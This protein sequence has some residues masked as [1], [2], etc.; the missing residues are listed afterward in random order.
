MRWVDGITLLV[1]GVPSLIGAEWEAGNE[2]LRLKTLFREEWEAR[3][4]SDPLT[5][6]LVGEH[7]W[8]SELPDLRLTEREASQARD[9]QFLDRLRDIDRERLSRGERVSCDLFEFELTRRMKRRGFGEHRLPFTSDSGFY[10]TLLRGFEKMRLRHERDAEIYLSRLSKVPVYLEQNVDLMRQGMA[11]GFTMPR[12]IMPGIERVI[13]GLS[14]KS[15]TEHPLFQ[16]FMLGLERLPSSRRSEWERRLRTLMTSR[17]LPAFRDLDSFVRETYS[18]NA[19]TSLG[20]RDLPGGEEY[21]RFLVADFTT[22]DLDPLEIHRMG[23]REVSRIRKE[24]ET[25]LNQLEFQG[26]F[27]DFLN[28]LRTDPQFYAQS[29]DQLLKEA[30]WIAKRVDGILPAY[31]ETLPRMPYGVAPVPRHL[32]P[33]YTTGRY[34]PGV[35]GGERGGYYWVNTFALEKR[36]LYA[37]PA[38]TLHEAMPG[39][40]LQIAL[41]QELTD[42]PDFRRHFYPNAFG[43]GWALYAEKLG[44]E[45]GVYQTIYEEFGCLTYEIW[46]AGRLVVDTGIHMMGWSRARAVELFVENSALSLHN[47]ETEVDRYIS[48][49]GQALSYKMGELTILRLRREAEQRL[50][51]RFDLREF[52]D[53]VLRNGGVTLS[54]LEDEVAQYVAGTVH[55]ESEGEPSR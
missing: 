5:A 8:D 36:P 31:F 9:R 25:I 47:I 39:H 18:P 22:L 13:G 34:S 12:I 24:M 45:M 14:S 19:R 51:Q 4:K 26:S 10:T 54:V 15:E 43:E 16:T 21:Y 7:R 6:T 38:L 23:L 11:T 35:P 41:A 44:K 52:H 27:S 17:V 32:A 3:L 49:P 29:A 28:F 2:S 20:A 55:Y 33:N 37:L 42:L 53:A 1:L 48:W 50:G 46:R 40:H 30:A